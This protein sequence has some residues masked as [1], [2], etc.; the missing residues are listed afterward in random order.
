MWWHKKEWPGHRRIPLSEHKHHQPSGLYAGKLLKPSQM[1]CPR[2]NVSP[3]RPANT[4]QKIQTCWQQCFSS[5]FRDRVTHLLELKAYNKAELLAQLWKNGVNRKPS[6]FGAVLQQVAAL[7]PKALLPLPSRVMCLRRFSETDQDAASQ[8]DRQTVSQSLSW[9]PVE[10][11]ELW[12]KPFRISCMLQQRCCCAFSWICVFAFRFHWWFIELE[13]LTISLDKRVPPTLSGHLNP[14]SEKSLQA[15]TLPC[16]CC[17]PHAPD[18][19]LQSPCLPQI[20]LRLYST[21]PVP[22]ALQTVRA[23][24]LPVDSFSQSGSI[25]EGQRDDL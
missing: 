6:S 25:F 7:R 8:P 17:R 4:V 13:S 19:G 18:P 5:L 21:A 12:H 20:R 16:S 11:L 14:T 10:S 9:C 24:D 3:M 22:Q 2:G 15:S 1:P 23:Q